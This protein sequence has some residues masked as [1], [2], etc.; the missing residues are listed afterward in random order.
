MSVRIGTSTEM[1][2]IDCT[3]FEGAESPARG[4]LLLVVSVQCAGFTGKIDTWVDHASWS[5]FLRQLG[6]LERHRQGRATVESIS[7]GELRLSLRV[8]DLAGHM[9]ID[10]F[11]G[12][13]ESSQE[14]RL[15]FSPIQFD[16]TALPEILRQVSAL[17]AC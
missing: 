10:G 4:D 5:D 15:E 3:E 2:E 6:D 13:R 16:P 17:A 7:P 9:A 8:T 11:V 14:I 12:V 1:V